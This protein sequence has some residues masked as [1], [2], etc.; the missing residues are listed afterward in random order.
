MPLGPFLVAPRLDPKPW[1]GSRL[2]GLGFAVDGPEPLGEVVMTATA[3]R[4]VG[5]PHAGRTL[6]E[7]IADDPDAMIGRRGLGATGGRLVFPLLVKLID[8]AEPLSIQVHPDDERAAVSDS[9]GKTEAWHI[10]TAEPGAAF[11]AGLVDGAGVADLEEAARAAPGTVAR[12]V[13][14][15][16]ARA[17]ET[18]FL[19]AGT[20]HALGAGVMLYEIQQASEITYRL[21]DWGRVGPDGR[22]RTMHVA[23]SLAAVE[24]AMR[25][26]II[27]PIR[28]G[29]GAARRDLL[30]A[31]RHFALDRWRI[32]P[33]A[34]TD[35]HAED[36]AQTITF[37]HGDVEL[38]SE[39]QSDAPVRVGPGQTAIVPATVGGVEVRAGGPAELLRAWVP[40]LETDIV[41]PALALGIGR[42][43]LTALSAPLP[44]VPAAIRRCD[45][46]RDAVARP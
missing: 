8:A 41:A 33:G 6:G 22:S 30:V 14:R 15:L 34:A 28:L 36:T 29:G 7:L 13:R 31:C 17:G 2:A 42:D 12:H 37:V 9:L 32:E 5:G 19:P 1:G 38:R 46:V 40:D 4:V 24:P 27:P 25:P 26:E 44:D 39:R 11:F 16:A 10:L 21:D 23:E 20:L 3:N 35:L 18:V 43:A 45:R